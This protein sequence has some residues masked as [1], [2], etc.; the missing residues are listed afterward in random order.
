M[1]SRVRRCAAGL[2][3]AVLAALVV[4]RP[5]PAQTRVACNITDITVKQLSNA[6][7]ITLKADGL[8]HVEVAIGEFVEQDLD[9]NWN[10]VGKREIPI[11]I[12]NA[13]SL[14]GTFADIGTYPVSHLQMTTPPDSREGVGLDV[15]LVLYEPAIVHALAVDNWDDF[16]WW[17][18]WGTIAFDVRKSQ[19]GRELQILVW[20]DR[21]EEVR[22]PAR[23]RREQ[24]LTPELSVGVEDGLLTVDC[25]NVPLEELAAEVAAAAGATVYV[26]DRVKRLAT[27]H[28][29][30]VP[31]ARFVT[32][33]AA[34]Y[35][36][37]VSQD[38]GA[39]LVSDGLPTS[40]A[41]YAAGGTRIY[42]LR[43]IEARDAIDLLPNF[44]LRYLKA[45]ESGDSII[46]Y[47][48][49]Q[50]LDRIGED[51]EDL[52]RPSQLIRVRTAVVEISDAETA[53]RLW[54][55]VGG[56]DTRVEI[57]G[58]EGTI[59]I[60]NGDEPF[61]EWVA[62]IRA[63]DTSRAL[64]L[65]ARPSLV[66]RPGQRAD[67]FVG[68]RQYYVYLSSGEEAQLRSAEAGV[69]LN[70]RPRPMGAGTIEVRLRLSVSTF[71]GVG[72]DAPLV[73][74]REART[75]LIM[76]DGDTA[77]VGGGMVRGS[78]DDRRSGPEPFRDAWLL[79]DITESRQREA[80]ATEIV[81]LISAEYAR[82]RPHE[83]DLEDQS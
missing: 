42:P 6:V 38:D 80:E 25:V 64:R 36:L 9:G 55:L 68:Q 60:E 2:A 63:L 45:S 5:A 54:R 11:R 4:A 69:N 41:P 40:L 13:R 74:T 57:D 18:D 70:I 81:F 51:I 72:S 21:H 49:S 30:A 15:R 16:D 73:D 79:R 65:R 53:R 34:G 39:W 17:V 19:S 14:V 77:V 75:T 76:A 50:L 67:L 24:G 37:T 28:M 3:V 32:S 12:T 27:V 23:P 26:D 82:S 62:N 58:S 8:L 35:G 33:V 22:A 59:R 10:R 1:S 56:D 83:A 47:G 43:Y 31:L 44:L 52:D 66:V 78:E 48:P 46:A 61:D 7:E 29:E 71:R 20:S